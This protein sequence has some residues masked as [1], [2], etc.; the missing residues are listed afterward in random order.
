MVA[1]QKESAQISN[2]LH[3]YRYK[4]YGGQTLCVFLLI[5]VRV[6]GIEPESDPWQ[7]PVLPLNHTRDREYYTEKKNIG[8]L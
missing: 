8:K 3:I 4:K 6:P 5:F 7:G 1:R 2:S